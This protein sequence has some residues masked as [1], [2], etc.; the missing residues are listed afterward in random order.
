MIHTSAQETINTLNAIFEKNKDK[1]ICVLAT[2]CCGKTTLVQQIPNCV[3]LDDVLW[4]QLTKEEEDY[5]CQKPWTNEIGAFTS[6]LVHERISIKPGHP[7]FSLILI[8]CDVIVYVDITDELL[9][10]HCKQR[11]SNFIDVKNVKNA[12]ENRWNNEREKKDKTFYYV[13]VTE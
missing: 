10:E 11:G 6:K 4:P 2:S 7:L 9:A 8:D 3:D 13:C 1:R 12:I 5:I